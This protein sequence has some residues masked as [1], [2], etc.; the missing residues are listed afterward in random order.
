MKIWIHSVFVLMVLVFI[1]SCS[2]TNRTQVVEKNPTATPM[3]EQARS[4]NPSQVPS[5]VLPQESAFSV[6]NPTQHQ[7]DQQNIV[8]TF[9]FRIGE[10]SLSPE[11]IAALNQSLLEARQRGQI[12]KI[13]VAVWSDSELAGSSG[14]EAPRPQVELA[15]ERGEN[16]EKYLDRMEPQT[17]IQIHNVSKDPQEVA[18]L[19]Q[20]QDENV[21]AQLAQMGVASGEAA[22]DVKGRSSSA[23]VLIEI[24]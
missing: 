13:H 12:A 17:D 16:I 15:K 22:D 14:V 19:I 20:D 21:Q 23:L 4:T 18:A 3:G 7:T 11:A 5:S 6:E 9:E 2:T 24:K 8:S 10:P 1:A